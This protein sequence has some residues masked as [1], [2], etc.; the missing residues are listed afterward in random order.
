VRVV[1]SPLGRLVQGARAA[2]G[3]GDGV[4]DLI[5]RSLILIIPHKHRSPS[6]AAYACS[7]MYRYSISG[8]IRTRFTTQFLWGNFATAASNRRPAR[9]ICDKHWFSGRGRVPS[10]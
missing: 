7:V 4:R 2:G 1:N 9:R 3:G 6:Q 8:T 10:V 5:L